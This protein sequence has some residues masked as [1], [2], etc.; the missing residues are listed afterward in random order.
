MDLFHSSIPRGPLHML[1]QVHKTAASIQLRAF[2]LLLI[3]NG[4]KRKTAAH[5]LIL[6]WIST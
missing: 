1:L 2:K 3:S 4:W 6:K 5:L